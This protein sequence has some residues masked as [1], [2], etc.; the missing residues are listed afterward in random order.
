LQTEITHVTI[1]RHGE[2]EW[3]LTGKHQGQLD[4]P[5]TRLGIAQAKAAAVYLKNE[6]FDLIYT[7]DLS[8]ARTTA[9]LINRQ[10]KL[11]LIVDPRLR[12][13]N[14]GL[15][16][17]LT[18]AEFQERHP[19]IYREYIAA[20][21]D[22]LIPGGESQRQCYE[23]IAAW[24][25]QIGR[26]HSGQSL[27]VVTHGIILGN[28]LKNALGIPVETKRHF[29]LFNIGINRF[30]I[31]QGSW[32]LEAWGELSHTKQLQIRDEIL[33]ANL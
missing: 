28:I 9:E 15:I 30:I 6:T 13:R 23:R 20:D 25:E 3:N 16:Q 26:C 33:G 12:E 5:L 29:S 17:G 2:T 21:P 24:M 4:S 11:Q 19:E 22:Y 14:L 10:L 8:R 27:L 32:Q 1:L 7:S 31:R 18:L